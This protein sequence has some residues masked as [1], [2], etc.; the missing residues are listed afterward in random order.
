MKYFDQQGRITAQE[1][2][3][4]NAS[5]MVSVK[6]GTLYSRRVFTLVPK[7]PNHVVKYI[8]SHCEDCNCKH[9][10]NYHG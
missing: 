10:F 3:N 7:Q 6:I 4:N 8:K 5:G 2:V 1:W 9:C